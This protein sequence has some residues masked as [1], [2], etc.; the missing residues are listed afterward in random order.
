MRRVADDECGHSS[1]LLCQLIVLKALWRC[2]CCWSWRWFCIIATVVLTAISTRYY[3]PLA[4]Q[5]NT[6]AANN[7]WR[8]W[9]TQL[10]PRRQLFNRCHNIRNYLRQT[11]RQMR[12]PAFVCL[13]VCLSVCEQDYSK[14]RAWMKCCVSTD[15]GTWTNVLVN[16]WAR[17]GL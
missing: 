6:E 11:R 1:A 2:D 10:L 8:R 7:S 4:L 17:S 9:T 15:V 3:Q 13:S 14:T 5:Y 16:F 12:L